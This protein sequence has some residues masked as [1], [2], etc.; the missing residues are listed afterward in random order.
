MGGVAGGIPPHKGGPKARPPRTAVISGQWSALQWPVGRDRTFG[1][2]V[3]DSGGEAVLQ[4]R[5]IASLFCPPDSTCAL[6]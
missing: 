3:F 4:S 6:D 5:G 1:R 2:N